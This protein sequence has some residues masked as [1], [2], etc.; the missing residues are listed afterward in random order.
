MNN[1]YSKETKPKLIKLEP[2]QHIDDTD[3]SDSTDVIC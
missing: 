2:K 3:K 1:E